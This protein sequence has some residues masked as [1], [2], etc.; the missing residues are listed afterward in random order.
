MTEYAPW[1]PGQTLLA[2]LTACV[3]PADYRVP[4]LCVRCRSMVVPPVWRV[5]PGP[6]GAAEKA[7]IVAAAQT[8]PVREGA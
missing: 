1:K 8:L 6:Y 5:C 3:A 7:R 2:T 4:P